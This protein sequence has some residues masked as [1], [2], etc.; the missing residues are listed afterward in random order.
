MKGNL[1][2]FL[3]SQYVKKKNRKIIVIYKENILSYDKTD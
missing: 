3:N 2:N 1:F